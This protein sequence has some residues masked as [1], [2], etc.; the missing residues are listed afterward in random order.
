MHLKCVKIGKSS[1]Q[2]TSGSMYSPVV[3]NGA[4]VT[5]SETALSNNQVFQSDFR[6]GRCL[7]ALHKHDQIF[8]AMPVASHVLH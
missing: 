1:Q 7:T 2:K 5:P 4:Q 3:S 8:Y 6:V